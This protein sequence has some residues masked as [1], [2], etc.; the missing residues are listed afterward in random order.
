MSEY[1]NQI[2]DMYEQQAKSE[3]AELQKGSIRPST[4]QLIE[5]QRR[6]IERCEPVYAEMSRL[7][8]LKTTI[9]I[10]IPAEEVGQGPSLLRDAFRP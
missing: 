1:L 9:E 6:H 3:I 5:I 2:L 7:E 4:R 8:G 10:S